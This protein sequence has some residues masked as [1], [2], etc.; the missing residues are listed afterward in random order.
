[1][2]AALCVLRWRTRMT[3]RAVCGGLARE[4]NVTPLGVRAHQFHLKLVT[5]TSIPCWPWMR[6]S[7]SAGGSKMRTKTPFGVTPVT[8]AAKVSPIRCWSARAMMRLF[9]TRSTLRAASS[10]SVQFRAIKSS[11]RSEYGD[12]CL[13]RTDL[14]SRCVTVSRKTAIGARWNACNHESA[15]AKCPGSCSPGR[16]TTYSPGPISLITAREISA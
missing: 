2:A 15:S 5:P 4:I 16:I 10:F 1:M 12:F 9:I 14:M 13:A 11:S 3:S 8:T 6:R 7:S